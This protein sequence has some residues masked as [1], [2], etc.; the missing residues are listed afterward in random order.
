MHAPECRQRFEDAMAA[1]EDGRRRMRARDVRHGLAE[2]VEEEREEQAGEE[3]AEARQEHEEQGDDHGN[4]QDE[5]NA[6]PE[7]QEGRRV[8]RRTEERRGVRK[9]REE[10]EDQDD[11]EPPQVSQRIGTLEEAIADI[12]TIRTGFAKG[13]QPRR[14]RIREEIGDIQRRIQECGRAN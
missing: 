11:D 10:G 1:T 8:R 2:E 14:R 3:K 6:D 5:P 7:P 12:I 4:D 13:E 9:P